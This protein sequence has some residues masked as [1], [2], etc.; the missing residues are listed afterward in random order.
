MRRGALGLDGSAPLLPSSLSCW[1]EDEGALILDSP[2]KLSRPPCPVRLSFL[3]KRWGGTGRGFCLHSWL[4]RLRLLT[5]A[6]R[7][8]R[9]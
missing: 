8:S 9:P 5:V 7:P 2:S 3:L 6:G 1:G 4:S